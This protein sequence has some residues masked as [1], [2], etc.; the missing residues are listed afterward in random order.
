MAVDRELYF[1]LSLVPLADEYEQLVAAARAADRGGLDLIGI[2]DHPYQR[3]FLDT[4]SLIADLL[5]RTERISFFPDVANLPL[6]HPA[7]I[8]KAA[9]SIDLMS[10][11]RFELGLG[12][13][14]FLDRVRAMGGPELGPGESVNALTEAIEVIRL[15][16]SGEPRVSFEGTHYRLDGATPGPA[17]AHR[18]GIWIGA[19]KPR[20]LRLVGERADGW[21]PSLFRGVTPETLAIASR[22]IDEAARA[23]GRDPREIRRVWNVPGFITD[24]D[25]VD[26]TH[27][28]A[29]E[30]AAALSLFAGEYGADAFIFWP[31]EGETVA[32]A[33]RFAADVVP[34][35]RQAVA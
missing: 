29:D 26:A 33:E 20:M 31:D 34:A 19:Y 12:A 6:R 5:A 17:P 35:V 3:R 21:V 1:G 22:D 10:D 15:M 4:W 25:P 30:I 11:G 14:G 9:A 7:M 16:W 2:Q 23:A 27:G 8:A 18:I 13:G 24:G 28:P 32:Q